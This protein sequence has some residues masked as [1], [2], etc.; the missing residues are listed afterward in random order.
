MPSM[1]EVGVQCGPG[2]VPTHYPEPL[3][4]EHA[5]VCLEASERQPQDIKGILQLCMYTLANTTAG[6]SQLYASSVKW[7]GKPCLFN[8]V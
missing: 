6:D 4:L 7:T 2:Q 5:K 3:H 1:R 8:F